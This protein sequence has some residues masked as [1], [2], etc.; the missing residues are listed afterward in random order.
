MDPSSNIYLPSKIKDNPG[1][2]V[3]GKCAFTN[4]TDTW[5]ENFNLLDNP[6]KVF[7]ENKIQYTLT[8][9]YIL[10]Y[11]GR[12]WKYT[13]QTNSPE[14]LYEL[15]DQMNLN[16]TLTLLANIIFFSTDNPRDSHPH[17]AT[18]LTRSSG[19]SQCF[20]IVP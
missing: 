2:G 11:I 14:E 9:D 18:L 3:N 20:L 19:S 13:E 8:G 15:N 12:I 4:G 6:R 16:A 17:L 5:E 10:D 1:L 7:D